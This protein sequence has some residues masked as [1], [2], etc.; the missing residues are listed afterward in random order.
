MTLKSVA[1]SLDSVRPGGTRNARGSLKGGGLRGVRILAGSLLGGV[2]AALNFDG[3][4]LGLSKFC[5]RLRML[6]LQGTHTLDTWRTAWRRRQEMV[7]LL[8]ACRISTPNRTES[9]RAEVR[10]VYL[11][12]TPKVGAPELFTTGRG[13]TSVNHTRAVVVGGGCRARAIRFI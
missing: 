1:S 11:R 9:A 5:G 8:G 13:T 6:L 2:P 7:L 4:M 10:R 12:R 3:P